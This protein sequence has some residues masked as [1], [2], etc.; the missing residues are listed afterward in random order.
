MTNPIDHGRGPLRSPG[1]GSGDTA[2]EML[3][4]Y[5]DNLLDAPAAARFEEQ[6]RADPALRRAVEAQRAL[7]ASLRRSYA[8]TGVSAASV[9]EASRAPIPIAEHAMARRDTRS[10]VR[11]AAAVVLLA[12]GAVAAR[13]AWVG[14]GPTRVHPAVAYT[15][16]V[17]DGM[18]PY[19]VCTTDEAFAEYTKNR[20]GRAF[21]VKPTEGLALIGWSYRADVLKHECVA[22]LATFQDQPVVVFVGKPG[23]DVAIPRKTGCERVH[24]GTFHD[25]VFYEVSKFETP[26][27][28]NRVVEP[29]Q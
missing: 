14:A 8:P 23:Q 19:E 17:A 4:R 25:L 16:I 3:E 13:Y 10:W 11:I 9:L 21:L 29:A 5:L 1:E 22:M 26:V 15:Q 12:A 18:K 28:I 7:D 2:T 27:M 24:R 6:L 20:L